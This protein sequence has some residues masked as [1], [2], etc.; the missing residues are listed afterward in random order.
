MLKIAT[1][2]RTEMVEIFNTERVDNIKRSLTTLGFTFEVEGRGK[3]LLFHIVKTPSEFK[4]FAMKEL[5][6]GAK[7]DFEALETFLSVYFNEEDFSNLMAIDMK[8]TLE[9]NYGVEISQATIGRWL[10][11][12]TSLGLIHN[13][14]ESSYF[15]RV[16]VN[17]T[18]VENEVDYVEI[19]QEEFKLG[20]KAYW[21]AWRITG[22]YND[23]FNAMTKAVGGRVFKVAKREEN[24]FE[25]ELL[26]KLYGILT[27][28][29]PIKV[30][31]EISS[32]NE[33]NIPFSEQNSSFFEQNL[34]KNDRVIN[35]TDKINTINKTEVAKAT[36]AKEEVMKMSYMDFRRLIATP[37]AKE[38]IRYVKGTTIQVPLGLR[39]VVGVSIEEIQAV[40]AV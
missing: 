7:T 27:V 25:T 29:K 19:T 21:E 39:E 31:K 4:M 2:T 3:N 28:V 20:W 22:V 10:D 18:G 1:Y 15:A 38:K 26:N 9:R 37:G 40:L 8:G 23:A 17:I 16:V 11:K 6:F 24:G 30:E 33:Q 14:S 35:K 5:G 12:L 32:E 36:P 13:S 34:P